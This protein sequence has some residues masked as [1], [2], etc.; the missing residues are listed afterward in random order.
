VPA[1]KVGAEL[2]LDVISTAYE[3]T[4]LIVTRWPDQQSSTMPADPSA[5]GLVEQCAQP[6]ETSG[7]LTTRLTPRSEWSHRSSHSPSGQ[8][9]GV[10]IHLH[11]LI[12]S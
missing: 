2:L 12:R 9:G 3:R 1:S 6:P 11:Y 10:R 7:Q 5:A 8:V 4:S